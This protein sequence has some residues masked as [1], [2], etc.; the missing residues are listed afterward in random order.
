VRYETAD[1]LLEASTQATV[2]LVPCETLAEATT[3]VPGAVR[4]S[5]LAAHGL[6]QHWLTEDRLADTLLVFV[7]DPSDLSAGPAWGLIRSAQT[8]HP[9]R[10]AL[11]DVALGA[12]GTDG[13]DAWPLLAA[14]LDAGEPQCAVRDGQ[15]LL[16]RIARRDT[17]PSTST[18]LSD[19]T[20]LITGGASGLG[21][22]TA[23]HLAEH[24]GARDLLLVSRRGSDTPGVA[25]LSEQLTGLGAR[26]RIE[27]CDAADR[28]ALA[29]LLGTIPADRPLTAVVHAAGAL[30]DAGVE[31]LRAEQFETVLLPK[32]DAAWNLHELTAGIPLRAFVLFSSVAGVI[33]TA[34]QGNYATA[35]AFLDTLATH[36]RSLGL[37]AVSIAWGLWSA[38]TGMTGTLTE[39]D[40]ARLARTGTAPLP[41]ETGLGLL[42]AALDSGDDD[43]TT[44]ASL[45]DLTALRAR[46]ADGASIPAVLRSL[47]RAPRKAARTAASS[48]TS[49][50][51]AEAGFA[52]R[53]AELDHDA[54][55][56]AVVELVRSR[57][58]AALAYPDPRAVDPDRPFA[59]LGFDSLTSVELRNRLSTDTGLRLPA[60]LVFNQPTVTGVAEYL[61]RELAPAEP[62]P[63]EALGEA[64][65]RIGELLEG[66]PTEERDRA[67]AL[68]EAALGRLRGGRENGGPAA[69]ALE[70]ASDE[71]IFQFL[72][73]RL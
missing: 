3:D 6:I 14:A 53:I 7:A 5:A 52:E 39:T 46:L 42:D 29:A 16:P 61:L 56:T 30:D 20:V 37:P 13:R 55:R 59:E 69:A 36:R 8:E 19:G 27:A 60:A 51:T 4:H 10:F 11:A 21:A 65:D 48:T 50:A 33:G 49:T 71:E 54:A 31:Q 23:L 18:D 63:A 26:V 38:A 17:P 32:V 25:E 67:E 68:L 44:V 70:F 2:V 9:G 28:S 41:T 43:A 34:G 58:A 35:N 45:W 72:D 57:V 1:G 15:L 66:A 47:V 40:V 64:L 73:S 22:L 24:H 12:E 62:A